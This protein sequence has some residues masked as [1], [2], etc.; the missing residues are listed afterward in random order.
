MRRIWH[1]AALTALTGA[2]VVLTWQH[3]RPAFTLAS[4]A[5]LIVLAVL[6]NVCYLAAYLV[7]VPMQLSGFGATWQQWRWVVWLFGTLFAL[8]FTYY[9]IADE[10]YPFVGAV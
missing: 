7:D 9:W 8:V 5:E 3:F 6:A 4:L 1:N 2:W 10:I